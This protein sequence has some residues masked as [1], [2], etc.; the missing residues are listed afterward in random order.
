MKLL[1]ALAFLVRLRIGFSAVPAVTRFRSGVSLLCTLETLPDSARYARRILRIDLEYMSE[2]VCTPHSGQIS[3]SY[4]G[5]AA[6]TPSPRRLIHFG[7]T[8]VP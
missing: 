6:T 2:V 1:C 7:R 3:S 5:H 4:Q 8:G